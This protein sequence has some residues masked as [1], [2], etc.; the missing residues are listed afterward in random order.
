MQCPWTSDFTFLKC[1]EK[2]LGKY[3]LP[4]WLL[5]L[6]QK[7]LAYGQLYHSKNLKPLMLIKNTHVYFASFR[8]ALSSL[9]NFPGGASEAKSLPSIQVSLSHQFSVP[10]PL[11]GAEP[12]QGTGWQA[13]THSRPGGP[14]GWE[15]GPGMLPPETRAKQGPIQARGPCGPQ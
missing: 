5:R 13:G 8:V 9:R 15:G 11:A 12:L 14:G 3:W 7:S 4:G 1:K 6:A 10:Q 2:E